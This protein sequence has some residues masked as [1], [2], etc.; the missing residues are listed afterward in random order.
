MIEGE[1]PASP[2]EV[3]PY[4]TKFVSPGYFEAMGTRMIVGREVTWTDIETGGRVAVVSEEFARKLAPEPA[5][6]LGKR[7]RTPFGPDAW[8]EVIGVVQNV[9]EDGLYAP[10]PSFVYWHVR[11]EGFNTNAVVGVPDVAFV[12]R[13]DRAGTASL[14][15]EVRRAAWSVNGYSGHSPPHDAGCALRLA[16]TDI[17]HARDARDRRRCGVAARCHRNLWRPYLRRLAAS[18]GNRHSVRAWC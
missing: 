17:V 11:M 13:S 2:G 9:H 3:P 6:A 18:S 16:R 7:I 15:E 8:R 4:R 5:D 12:I 1:A 14:M 10:P